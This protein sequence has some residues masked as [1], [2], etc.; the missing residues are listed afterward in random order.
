[1]SG[2]GDIIDGKKG[3]SSRSGLIYTCRCGWIDLG[4]A[5]PDSAQA[6][7]WNVSGEHGTV[8]KDGQGFKVPYTQNMSQSISRFR[9]RVGVLKDFYVRRGLSRSE[10]ESVALSIFMEI[11][12]GF[13]TLQSKPPF[14]WFRDS[15]FSAEDLVS[16]LIGFYR[17]V[18][19]GTDYISM[20]RPVSKEAALKVWDTYGSVGSNK[21]YAF[22][23]YVYPSDECR[24]GPS[25]PACS[26]L[27]AALKAIQPAE[28]GTLFRDWKE[29]D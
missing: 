28:K 27:P 10:R 6:L 17:A 22:S 4:H 3:G 26:Q 23:P 2:R 20:C 1:M 24:G 18:K 16:N 12:L 8:S 13:E 14:G 11:S 7:W 19:P 5:R 9:I 25:G 15:G 29:S 21:N